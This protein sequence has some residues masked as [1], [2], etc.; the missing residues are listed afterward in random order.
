MSDENPQGQ[1]DEAK[2]DA[3]DAFSEMEDEATEMGDQLEA[4][5]SGDE[6]VEVPDPEGDA[7]DA[8]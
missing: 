8:G 1:I 3:D 6:D 2:S 4:H 5:E 7:L